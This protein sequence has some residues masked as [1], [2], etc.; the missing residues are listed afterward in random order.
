MKRRDIAQSWFCQPTS[1]ITSTVTTSRVD[2]RM[3]V[4]RK[5]IVIGTSCCLILYLLYLCMSG[6]ASARTIH[7]LQSPGYDATELVE[8]HSSA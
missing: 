1:L 7:H 8:H 5:R 6:K 2:V 3:Q 4:N